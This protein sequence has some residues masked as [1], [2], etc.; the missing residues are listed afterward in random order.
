MTDAS[1]DERFARM[2]YARVPP[3]LVNSFSEEQIAAIRDAFGA[4][5][6][7]RHP[8]DV[9]GTVPLPFRRWYFVF[10]AGPDK[11]SKKRK[12][13]QAAR[14]R[15]PARRIFGAA[16]STFALIWLVLLVL[17]LLLPAELIEAL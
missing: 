7:D 11:R 10:V 17:Y 5:R 13:K 1:V 14:E 9:R 6:W 16:V 8:V 12:R 15:R 4:E 2:F 3:A